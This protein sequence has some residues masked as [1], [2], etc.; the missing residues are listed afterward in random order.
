VPVSGFKTG[1]SV[2]T[3]AGREGVVIHVVRRQGREYVTVAFT[4]APT[5]EYAASALIPRPP[6]RRP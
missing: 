2:T 5:R 3:L 1:E 4:D 6:R